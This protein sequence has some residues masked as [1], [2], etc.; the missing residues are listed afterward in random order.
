MITAFLVIDISRRPQ[1][2]QARRSNRRH[3]SSW[4]HSSGPEA[5]HGR[6][7]LGTWSHSATPPPRAPILPLRD[8]R[9][10]PPVLEDRQDRVVRRARRVL[11]RAHPAPRRARPCTAS[12]PEAG[13]SRHVTKLLKNECGQRLLNQ[14]GSAELILTRGPPPPRARRAGRLCGNPWRLAPLPRERVRGLA[15][16]RRPVSDPETSLRSRR[17]RGERVRAGPPAPS[18]GTA[19]TP[20]PSRGPLGRRC[21]HP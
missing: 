2:H 3:R 21:A 20:S 1:A 18:R 6:A 10:V 17:P 7:R 15:S 13:S 5:V 9:P 11:R 4:S 8:R 14:G 12:G 16:D 19:P